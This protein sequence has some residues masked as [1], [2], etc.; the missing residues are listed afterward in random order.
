MT[1]FRKV[2]KEGGDFEDSEINQEVEKMELEERR[3]VIANK[4]RELKLPVDNDDCVPFGLVLLA[5][6][7]NAFGN[8]E[9][10]ELD[11]RNPRD[12]EILTKIIKREKKA[13]FLILKRE[14]NNVD[15]THLHS[16]R[17]TC[18]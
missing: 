17:W 9:N 12:I 10:L 18:F 6:N 8:F 5:A 13:R 7:K 11:V 1:G 2:L 16:S 15:L 3:D 14:I 4:I